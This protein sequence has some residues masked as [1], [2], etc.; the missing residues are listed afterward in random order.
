MRG[1]FLLARPVIRFLLLGAKGVKCPLKCCW[2]G[3]SGRS[4]LFYVERV[5]SVE[6]ELQL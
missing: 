5:V 3:E 2:L 1:S 4:E 6:A